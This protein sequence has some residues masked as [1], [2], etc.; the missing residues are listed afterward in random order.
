MVPQV[1]WD[2]DHDQQLLLEAGLSYLHAGLRAG[3]PATVGPR[4]LP[5]LEQTTNRLS[6]RAATPSRPTPLTKSYS[7]GASAATSPLPRG[8]VRHDHPVGH[9][10][11]HVSRRTGRSTRSSPTPASSTRRPVPPT[12]CRARGCPA[13][14]RSV[15]ENTPAAPSRKSKAISGSSCQDSGTMSRLTLNLVARF[16]HFNAECRRS[17]RL[18]RSGVHYEFTGPT[19]P[20]PRNF[21][22]I[23]N[24]RTE[25]LVVRSRAPTTCLATARPPSRRTPASTCAAAAA[26]YAAQRQSR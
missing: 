17:P 22:A 2:T 20:T 5:I 23:P 25:R 10:L 24:V 16:D 12:R 18:R 19:A 9:E 3:V 11:A 1:K 13:R 7:G 8:Q 14:S 4:D 26:G 15:V 6:S 21:P